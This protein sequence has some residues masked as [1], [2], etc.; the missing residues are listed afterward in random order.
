MDEETRSAFARLDRYFELNQAQFLELSSKVTGLDGKVT[1]LDGKVTGLES[2]L[3]SFR[4]WTV[5]QFMGVRTDLAAL[6]EWAE[7]RL[8]GNS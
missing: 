2:Q 3:R 5:E 1:G 4:D 7:S 6:R 8:T